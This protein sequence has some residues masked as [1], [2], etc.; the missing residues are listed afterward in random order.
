MYIM[1]RLFLLLTLICLTAGAL[2]AQP[3]GRVPP[4]MVNPDQLNPEEGAAVLETF[5]N[6]YFSG[7]LSF[8]FELRHLPRRGDSRTFHGQLWTTWTSAGPLHRVLMRTG[9]EQEL[10]ASFLLQ[11]G[12]EPAGWVW[13]AEEGEVQALSVEEQF[14]GLVPGLQV[15]PFD[16]QM[17]FVYWKDHVYE[18]TRR[19]RGRPAHYFLLYPPEEQ[20]ADLAFPVGAVRVIIDAG[21]NALLGVEVM[22]PDGSALKSWSIQSFRKVQEQWIVRIIDMVDEVTRDRTRFEIRAAA[23]NQ[24]FPREIFSVK[25]LNGIPN[26]PARGE[27]HWL[28]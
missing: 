27:F 18:G 14:Q 24:R 15:T 7:E 19:L 26:E 3:R 12:P 21:F 16:L 20:T 13:N 8:L 6:S 11:S 2:S 28:N 23:M 25:D 17:S 1:S 5:R 22:N 4:N 10:G 9:L